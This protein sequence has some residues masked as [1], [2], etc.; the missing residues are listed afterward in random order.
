MQLDAS[1]KCTLLYGI[2]GLDGKEL[3]LLDPESQQERVLVKNTSQMQIS[4]GAPE[5]NF[6]IFSVNETAPEDK[7]RTAPAHQSG[8]QTRRFSQ[9]I[10]AL[11]VRPEKPGFTVRLTYG[12]ENA[13]LAGYQCR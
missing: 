10:I 13:G 6:L 7:G 12:K 11:F 4:N 5:E 9:Q 2:K 1:N 3:R 8:R